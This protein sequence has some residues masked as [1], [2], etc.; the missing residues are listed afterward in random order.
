MNNN[1]INIPRNLLNINFNPHNI[2]HVL[3]H[4]EPLN[5]EEEV[6]TT[7]SNSH[8][9]ES[10]Q[11]R[12]NPYNYNNPE[13]SDTLSHFSFNTSNNEEKDSLI[14]SGNLPQV[15]KMYATKLLSSDNTKNDPNKKYINE[16]TADLLKISLQAEDQNQ[17]QNILN[18][19]QINQNNDDEILS[20]MQQKNFEITRFDTVFCLS[21]DGSAHSETAYDIVTE[22]FLRKETDKLLIVHI[23]NSSMDENYNFR[24]R[25]D[26]ITQNYSTRI[27]KL[28]KYRV[29]FLKEDRFSKVHALEQVNRIA[30]NHKCSY[31]VSGYYGIKG[32]KGD[33]KELSKGVDYL[34]SFSRTPTIIIKENT[35]RKN[36]PNGQIKWLF[37]FDR[38][39]MN[40]YSILNRFLPLINNETDYVFGYTL[41][42]PW[43]NFDDIKKNFLVDMELCSIKN[44][45]YETVEYTKTSSEFV[46]EK[47]NF[48]ETH[49]DYLVFYNTS[50]KH[51]SE[52]QNSD[53]VNI[54]TKC[55]SNVCF[56]N[57]P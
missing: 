22:D 56:L 30:A 40:C 37:V 36:K 55:A 28:E 10:N 17:N 2:N 39:Y 7:I 16:T 44:F 52:G 57:G 4:N 25:M 50:V 19:P 53:I 38:A 18:I 11:K 27:L 46:K 12:N 26:T 9:S 14:S 41:L 42:P 15:D 21:I 6:N 54:V 45:D 23:Y 29:L 24:N 1:N 3:N 51:R 35:L 48:G 32:P 13:H 34:L 5:T 49:F 20:H 47:V 43:I 33:N 8:Q 31:L